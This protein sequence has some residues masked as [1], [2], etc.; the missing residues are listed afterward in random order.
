M[1]K[2]QNF[3]RVSVVVATYNLKD[4]FLQCLASIAK[5]DYSDLKII[6]VDNGS[7]DGTGEAVKKKFPRVKLIKNAKNLGVTGGVNAGL[8]EATGDY[9]WF[10]DHDNIFKPK[11]LKEMVRLAESDPAIG[12]VVPKIYYWKP[13]DIIWAA[14]TGINLLTGEN[15]SREGKDVGQYDKV[16]EIQV[17]PANFLVKKAVIDKVGAYDDIYFISYEDADLSFRIR[18]AGYKIVYTPKAVCY[19]QIP[20]LDKMSMKKR[21]LNR[22]YWTSRN[23][24]IFMRKHSPFFA[25]FVLLYP[26]WF[27]LYTYQAVRYRNFNALLNFYK[28]VTAGFKWAVFDYEG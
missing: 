20:L 14:G 25:I 27:C 18:K 8:K 11:M 15:L 24:I 7:T 13:K 2:E 21:W 19:H 22:A 3:P 17:A 16:E 12:V 1:A 26:I 10:V 28:G 6:V 5:Q 23:K 4:T 9:I